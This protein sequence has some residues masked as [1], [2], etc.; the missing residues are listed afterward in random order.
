[1]SSGQVSETIGTHMWSWILWKH[2]FWHFV[3]F[4]LHNIQL[5]IS[6]SDLRWSHIWDFWS[7][8]STKKYSA[9]ALPTS[10][11]SNFFVFQSYVLRFWQH[12]CLLLIHS[13]PG[14]FGVRA[15]LRRRYMQIFTHPHFWPIVENLAIS[16]I[17]GY[18]YI[19]S[20]IDQK[21][22]VYRLLGWA[23]TSKDPG[24]EWIRSRQICCQNLS[25]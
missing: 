6:L 10:S 16:N 25:P 14:S 3:Q 8:K 9:L 2:D 4:Q 18:Y 23:R 5:H 22:G 7:K 12:I 19:F 21:W 15:H 20:T 13:F 17:I 24:N 11:C 1:M